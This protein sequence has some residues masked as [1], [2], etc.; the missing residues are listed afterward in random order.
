MASLINDLASHVLGPGAVND[1]LNLIRVANEQKIDSREVVAW[2]KKNLNK[3]EQEQVLEKFN[4]PDVEALPPGN[5]T[6]RW[7]NALSWLANETQDERR[8]LELQDF[9]G[10]AIQTPKKKAAPAEPEFIDAEVVG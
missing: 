4:S 2:A 9:A 10:N 7:S 1:F 6:W 8:K 5:T 3:G